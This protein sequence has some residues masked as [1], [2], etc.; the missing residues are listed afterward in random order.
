MYEQSLELWDI[1][2]VVLIVA[3][4][5]YYI[6]NKLFKKNNSCGSGCDSCANSPGK[7]KKH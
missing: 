4:A 7:E 6:Y 3:I 2:I 1:A 5:G